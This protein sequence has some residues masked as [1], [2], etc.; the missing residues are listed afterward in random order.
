MDKGFHQLIKYTYTH[1]V[2]GRLEEEKQYDFYH[3]AF[4]LQR[5]ETCLHMNVCVPNT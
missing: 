1:L 4:L 5:R 2:K 3:S